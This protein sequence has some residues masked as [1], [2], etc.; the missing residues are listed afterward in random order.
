M[1][2]YAA[3]LIVILFHAAFIRADEPLTYSK[4]V[5]PFLTQYCHTCHNPMKLQGG[6]NVETVAGMF[7][8]GVSGPSIIPGKPDE[9]YLVTLSEGKHEP[10]MPPKSALKKPKPG[11]ADVLRAWVAAGGIDDTNPNPIIPRQVPVRAAVT[12]LAYTQRRQV[13]RRRRLRRSLH[14]RY[15]YL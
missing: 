10:I 2:R 11:E 9:S 15:V 5:K 12:A 13:P 14:L 3:T 1:K 8:G 6:L 4:H 7:K